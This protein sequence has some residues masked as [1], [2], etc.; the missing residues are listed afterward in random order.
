M[1]RTALRRR[2]DCYRVTAAALARRYRALVIDDTDL[3]EFQRSPATESEDVERAAVKRQQRLAAGSDL[4]SA[5]INAFRGRVVRLSA[6]DV[7][8]VHAACGHRNARVD[9]RELT[10]G[11]CGATYD[12]DANACRNLLRE[13]SGAGEDGATARGAKLTDRK[14]SRGERLSAARR[15]AIPKEIAR[16]D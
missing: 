6:A 2:T 8:V 3:R 14:P 11:G 10:C 12:Q 13:Q 16:N 4:R 9:S 7:T 1:R 15:R 5:L